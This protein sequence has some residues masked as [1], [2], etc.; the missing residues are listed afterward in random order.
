MTTGVSLGMPL[1]G[2]PPQPPALIYQVPQAQ[3]SHETTIPCDTTGTIR[4][5]VVETVTANRSANDLRVIGHYVHLVAE[6]NLR[7]YTNFKQL[8]PSAAYEVV[9]RVKTRPYLPDGDTYGIRDLQV[10]LNEDN[11]RII[12]RYPKRPDRQV[13]ELAEDDYA[14][15][16]ADL[17]K[18][19]KEIEKEISKLKK[20]EKR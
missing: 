10:I 14:T 2:P 12:V 18:F 13:S 4:C 6:R 15:Y 7:Y 3:S 8:A 17:T 1:L 9:R 19:M 11:N 20:Y 16:E 5:S